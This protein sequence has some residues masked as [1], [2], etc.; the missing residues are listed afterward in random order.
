[1]VIFPFKSDTNARFQ[2]LQAYSDPMSDV[3]LMF[4]VIVKSFWVLSRLIMMNICY[5]IILFVHGSF[6]VVVHTGTWIEVLYLL[7]RGLGSS[8]VCCGLRLGTCEHEVVTKCMRGGSFE[9]ELSHADILYHG[10]I[11]QSSRNV[12]LAS[13]RRFLVTS[14]QHGPCSKPL[15]LVH[16]VTLEAK[17]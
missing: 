13:R 7:G 10:N 3:Y 2:Q 6:H 14:L 4:S 12:R 8:R 17:D 5:T 9:F 16:Y 1:M 11:V 15:I